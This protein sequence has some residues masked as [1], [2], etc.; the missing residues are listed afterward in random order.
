MSES[1]RLPAIS[2]M[3]EPIL[4]DDDDEDDVAAIP[5]INR[6]P[7][8]SPSGSLR[9]VT[10]AMSVETDTTTSND[11]INGFVNSNIDQQ[12]SLDQY[13]TGYVYSADMML[14]VNPVDPE[15]P[16]RPLRIWKIYLKFKHRDLFSRMKRIPIREVTRAEV[17]LVHDKGIW[18]GVEQSARLHSDFLKEQVLALE[19][20]SSLYI[21]EH[22][23]YAARLSCGGAIELCDA[24]AAGRIQNGFAIVRPPGHHAEPHR[25]MGFCFYNNVAVAT[26]HVMRKHDH[27]NKV[28]ILDWDVHHGNG[29]Q[30]AFEND[31]DVLYIS[32][33]RYDA[34]GSFYPGSSYGNYDS[35]GT[36]AGKGKSVNVPWPTHGMGDADYMYAFQHLVMPI[37]YQFEPDLVIISAGFDAAD[38]DPIGLN[39][40]SPGGFAQMTHQLTSLC[41]GKVA[42]VLEG[43]YNPDAVANSALAVTE[44]LL[45]LNTAEPR[46]TVA[47]TI[48]ANTV[49]RVI[50]H[51]KRYWPSLLVSDIEADDVDWASPNP[52]P[53]VDV[54]ELLA[55]YRQTVITE[56]YDLFEVPLYDSPH[57]AFGGHALCSE[58]ILDQFSTI[59]FFV[60]DMGNL[61]SERPRSV[62]DHQKEAYRLVDASKCVMDYAKSQRYGLVD[63]NVVRQLSTNRPILPADSRDLVLH[64]D[65][66]G[67]KEACEAAEFIWDNIIALAGRLQGPCDVVLMGLGTGCNVLT[68]I[69]DKKD[70][71]SRVKAVV[72]VVGYGKMPGISV[73]KDLE[74]KKWYYKNSKVL[75]PA[76]HRHLL[77]RGD[78]AP[79]KRYGRITPIHK[80]A[81]I[82]VL[83]ESMASIGVF[84]EKKLA[85]AKRP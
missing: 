73:A 77:E 18:D 78:A 54:I 5:S 48:A 80:T 9:D 83:S 28:L 63:I 67:M 24:V 37:A 72:H 69:I 32:I 52:P 61:R 4:I 19:S 29:T 40:V 16:E 15:H 21:N 23:A 60:H 17:D 42:V 62:L 27:I 31:A 64:G 47:S 1:S 35:D 85:V 44:V 74:T 55:A 75:A 7:A 12:S 6:A 36:G 30:K 26:R 8:H 70:V 53:S 11:P 10:P 2:R 43:G 41:Q 3:D 51:H 46:E 81:P 50:R 59:I 22:S 13:R 84:I 49:H 25:S 65:V 34:D 57:S 58:G 45:S 76:D 79:L 68:N 14:H 38:G 56:E 39:R 82:N 71:K 33:H 20:S 66:E